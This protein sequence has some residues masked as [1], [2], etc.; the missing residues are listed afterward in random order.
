MASPTVSVASVAATSEQGATVA[1]AG[2]AIQYT[3]ASGFSGVDRFRVTFTSST[4]TIVGLIEMTTAVPSH[5]ANP[6]RLTPLSGGRMGIQFNGIPGV[7]YQLQRST[8][9]TSWTT[10]ATITAGS[11][12]EID[13]TDNNPPA[14][15][16]FYRLFQP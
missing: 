1:L 5:L 8:D 2:S 3:P 16:G 12:G 15:N 11:R 10:I 6:A 13:F 9:L 4:G 7:A 14:P